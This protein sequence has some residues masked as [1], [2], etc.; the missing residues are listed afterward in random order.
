MMLRRMRENF[1]NLIGNL[2]REFERSGLF[3]VFEE[4]VSENGVGL[5]WVLSH[6]S[7]NYNKGDVILDWQGNKN[8]WR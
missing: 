7:L 8:K 4:L 1:V 2:S 3:E 6:I 5:G